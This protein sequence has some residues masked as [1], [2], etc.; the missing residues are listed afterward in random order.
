MFAVLGVAQPTV[1]DAMTTHE[2]FTPVDD[3]ELA[4]VAVVQHADVAESFFMEKHDSASGFFHL[5]P[6]CLAD[7]FRARCVKQDTHLLAGA[8]RL[9]ERVRHALTEH[10][11]LPKKGFEMH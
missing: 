2:G 6:S 7:F 1:Y 5:S 8:S 3:D 10:P 9:R 4:M 11:F